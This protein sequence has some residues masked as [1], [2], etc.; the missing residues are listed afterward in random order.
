MSDTPTNERSISA[1]ALALAETQERL[2]KLRATFE[3]QRSEL[4]DHEQWYEI[5][6][7]GRWWAVVQ[8]EDDPSIM[9]LFGNRERACAHR[10][11]LAIE[12]SDDEDGECF[13]TVMPLETSGV[14]LWNTY[15]PEVPEWA[16][17]QLQAPAKGGD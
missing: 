2:D 12:W 16:A 1:V 10:D 7:D 4:R 14:R 13:L 5:N 3:R 11:M 6:D 17:I 8:G 9:A 15:D